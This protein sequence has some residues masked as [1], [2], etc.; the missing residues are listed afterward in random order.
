MKIYVILKYMNKKI[1]LVIIINLCYRSIFVKYKNF[2]YVYN[3][4]IKNYDVTN[5]LTEYI[6]SEFL[7]DCPLN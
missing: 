3:R 1:K 4:K 6:S 2:M 5:I 7:Y